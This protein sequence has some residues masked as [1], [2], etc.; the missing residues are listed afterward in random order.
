MNILIPGAGGPAA[1]GA[2]KLLRMIDF[3]GKIVA[4][5]SSELSGGFY[6]ADSW[7]IVPPA[8]D[9]A[10]FQ[11][12]L[13]IIEEEQIDLI[14]PT[15]GFDIVP[16]SK[17]KVRLE[18]MGIKVA[19]SDHKTVMLC[20]DKWHLYE[21]L[22]DQ[23]EMPD[24]NPD[25]CR[26]RFP[27][28][29]KPRWG[30]GSR[31]SFKCDDPAELEYFLSKYQDMIVQEYLPGQEYTIDVLSD[32][33]G[34]SFFAVPRIRLETK[35]GISSK[36]RVELNENIERTCMLIANCLGLQGP[37]CMQMKIDQE[38][39]PRL[40]DVNPRMGGGTIFTGLAGANLPEYVLKMAN[41]E[42]LEK[43]SL[44]EITV[45]RYYNEVVVEDTVL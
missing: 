44:R 5:D 11:R 37:S 43:P 9:S 29:V 22:K 14:L 23:F 32:L 40:I 20:N 45:V 18:G 1:I 42:H 28:F 21:A 33:T 30:K 13:Q 38:G 24:T 31:N 26:V 35:A 10:F 6:L 39:T 36:G 27:C 7:R 17:H 12:A 41:G 25:A 19:M 2:I 8:D 15:S 16:Y 3:K 4:T 34:K